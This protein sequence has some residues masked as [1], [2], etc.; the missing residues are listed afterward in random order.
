MHEKYYNLT[1]EFNQYRCKIIKHGI[2]DT[3]VFGGAKRCIVITVHLQDGMAHIDGAGWHSYCN[4]SNNFPK[5]ARGT[6]DMFKACINF[7]FYKYA[8]HVKNI[9]LVDTSFI[10]CSNKEEIELAPHYIIKT[11][12]TWYEK[13]LGFRLEDPK[14]KERY[15]HFIKNLRTSPLPF[16]FDEFSKRFLKTSFIRLKCLEGI[17]SALKPHYN[18]SSSLAEFFKSINAEYDCSIFKYWLANFTKQYSKINFHHVYWTLDKTSWNHCE[19]LEIS[20]SKEAFDWSQFGGV[21]SHIM[22]RHGVN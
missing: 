10:V 1:S 15:A 11:G 21:P 12:K 14:D 18:R 5:A 3:V 6:L 9:T 17:Y 16:T 7:I 8:K 2:Y 22:L 4:K 13:H 20:R 19:P